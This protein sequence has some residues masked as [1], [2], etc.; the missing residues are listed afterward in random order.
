MQRE[1]L[2]RCGNGSGRSMGNNTRCSSA[3]D[4]GRGGLAST[5]VP[6][7]Y[8]QGDAQLWS[9]TRAHSLLR[10]SVDLG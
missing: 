4:V 6:V 7:L 9:I 5:Q 2:Y 3:E 10:G 8:N 1:L